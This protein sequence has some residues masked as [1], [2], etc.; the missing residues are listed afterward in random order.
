MIIKGII[1]ENFQDYKKTS[2]YI[3]LPSCTFKCERDCGEYCCANE[4]LIKSSSIEINKE[5]LVLRYLQNDTTT[6]I[7]IGGLEPFDTFGD[8]YELIKHFRFST[9]DDIVVYTGYNK[10]EIE[11]MLDILRK[12]FVNIIVKFGRYVPNNPSNK[13]DAILGVKL[14]SANQYALK[15]S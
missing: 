2:L 1:D 11:G 7:V 5:Q 10:G 14:A 12:Q 4:R 15:I 8:L 9:N 13:E 3:A 6:A